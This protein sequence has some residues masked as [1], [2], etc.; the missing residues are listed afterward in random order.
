MVYLNGMIKKRA[1]SFIEVIVATMLV[2]IGVSVFTAVNLGY[3]H[4]IGKLKYNY[5]AL[6]LAREIQEYFESIRLERNWQM[7]Y[8]YA[9]SGTCYSGAGPSASNCS[10][11]ALRDPTSIPP[12]TVTTCSG[13]VCTTTRYRP[14]ATPFDILG[15]VGAKGLVPQGVPNSVRIDCSATYN[16]AYRAY[17]VTTT[18]NWQEI[19]PGG[20][21]ITCSETLSSIPLTPINNQL[22][23]EVGELRWD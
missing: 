6:N 2:A 20:S 15:N 10:G 12:A 17:V 7:S 1:F 23:M 16:G 3:K 4:H 14:D 8:Y 21:P 9:G 18:I 22:M 11:Y 5:T 13:G 19:T